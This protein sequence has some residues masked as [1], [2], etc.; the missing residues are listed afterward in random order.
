MHTRVLAVFWRALL[1]V[2]VVGCTRPPHPPPRPVILHTSVTTAN[3]LKE[4][5]SHLPDVTVQAV[6]PGGSSVTSLEDLQRGTTDVGITM[7]DVAYLAFAGQ[8]D[9][10]PQVFDQLRGMAVLNLNTLH[11][12]AGAKSGIRTIDDLRGKHVALGPVGSA[13]AL[14]A[15]MLLSAYGVDPSHV[16]REQL[17]YAITAEQL[18]RGDLDAAFMTQTPPSGPVVAATR[19]GARLMDIAGPQVEELRT[20]HP[21]LKRTLIPANSYPNQSK[22]VHTVGVDLVLLCR[23]DMDE[24]IVYRLLQGYFARP[25]GAPA[26]ADFERAPATPIPLH[27]G[28]ARYY[29]QRELAR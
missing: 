6:T 4:A 26:P 22:A 13:T 12:I 20:R 9:E 23:A 29:R 1:C 11:L 17:P 5:F 7:A 15:E 24:D 10:T 2:S 16:R 3:D 8:L 27:A 18:V 21:F 14:L 28:A 19:E 25:A